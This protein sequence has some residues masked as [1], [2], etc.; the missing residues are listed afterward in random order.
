[1]R[2]IAPG[3]PLKPT[4]ESVPVDDIY[5]I[6][7]GAL[8]RYF[9]LE[10]LSFIALCVY[11][12]FE[13]VR[14]QQ[15]H[16]FID[17]LPW[18]QLSL[19]TVILAVFLDR[20]VRWVNDSQ[21]VLMILYFLIV[22]M[23]SLLAFSPKEAFDNYTVILNWFLIYFLMINIL[24]SDKRLVVFVLLFLMYN[25]KMAQTGFRTF[26]DRGF[27][28][29]LHGLV[30]APGWFHN[31]GEYATALL[32]FGALAMA[33]AVGLFSHWNIY[34]K[35]FFVLMPVVGFVTVLGTNS[36]GGQ[37]GLVAML[38]WLLLFWKYRVKALIT[39]AV[40]VV[41]GSQLIP[42]EQFERFNTAGDDETSE[43]RL[44]YWG[45]GLD[46]MKDYPL[47][48]VGFSNWYHYVSYIRPEGIGPLG[49]IEMAHNT[50]IEAGTELGYLGLGVYVLMILGV[51]YK[52][53]LTRKYAKQC[54]D[55]F[56]YFMAYAFDAALIG[57]LVSSF[58]MSILHYPFFWVQLGMSVAF[59]NVARNKLKATADQVAIS[60]PVATVR[61]FQ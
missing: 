59:C 9:K 18:A 33:F 40:I 4:T 44:E 29:Q 26:A 3:K 27:S 10:H 28:F 38:V 24:N 32:I 36:R 48:G 16:D 51:F 53:F 57:Y 17:V 25:F 43:Q 49:E 6:K 35:I 15:I 20:T 30:G 22:I 5:A 12:F 61:S 31:S 8:W 46:I 39:V 37:L 19:L 23:S 34:K 58:F 47:F 11:F 50:F 42:Q 52:N 14:P 21:N 13:Y 2:Q 54:D 45:L 1:M 56:L 7:F 55:K 60:E 41:L